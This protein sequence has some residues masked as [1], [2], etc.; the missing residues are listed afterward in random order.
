MRPG[1]G[2]FEGLEAGLWPGAAVH[3][4]HVDLGG[5][6]GRGSHLGRR[7]IDE[8]QLFP[9]GEARNDRQV[10]CA[11]RHFDGHEELLEVRECLEHQEVH[12]ALEKTIDLFAEGRSYGRRVAV[13][14]TPKATTLRAMRSASASS[15]AR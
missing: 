8:R 15:C 4:D 12:A 2:P 7:A 5:F 14:R 13:V 10:G 1:P 9:E 11:T 3:P 6:E